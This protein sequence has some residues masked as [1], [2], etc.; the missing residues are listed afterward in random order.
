MFLTIVIT[1][2]AGLTLVF[3]NLAI[4]NVEYE[5]AFFP[6]WWSAARAFEAAGS[7]GQV[8][9]VGALSTILIVHSTER[10]LG[11]R[12]REAGAWLVVNPIDLAS[13]SNLDARSVPSKEDHEPQNDTQ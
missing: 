5:A 10:D 12:L 7:A 11:A 3:S 9:Q 13:C 6:P 1:N 2:F 4:T 8:S